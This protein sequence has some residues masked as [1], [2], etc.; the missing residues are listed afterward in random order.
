[1]LVERID[2]KGERYTVSL[3]SDALVRGKFYDFAKADVSLTAGGTYTASLG[4]RKITFKIDPRAISGST[5]IIG[6]LL[7]LE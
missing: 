1:M 4:A 3:K 5:P 6:R 2:T 7:R